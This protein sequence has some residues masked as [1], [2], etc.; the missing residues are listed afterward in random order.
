MVVDCSFIAVTPSFARVVKN[1]HFKMVVCHVI[2]LIT[3]LCT[4][5]QQGK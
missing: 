4:L 1:L 2:S 5:T 3:E